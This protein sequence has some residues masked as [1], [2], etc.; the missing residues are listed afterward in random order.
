MINLNLIL[1]ST[2][3]GD[4][5]V[6]PNLDQE[7]FELI[8]KSSVAYKSPKVAKLWE[9]CK[10][11]IYQLT[12]RTQSLG[13]GSKG[14]TMYFSENCTQDDSDRVKEWMKVKKMD[15]F[16]CRTFKTEVDGHKTYEIK[17]ASVEKGEKIGITMPPEEYKGDTFVVTRGDFSNLLAKI[18]LNLAEAKKYAANENQDLMIRNYIESFAEG[19]L[20][21]HKDASR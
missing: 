10:K 2:G 11:S 4:S 15:A 8:I 18:N 19:S 12:E 3:F 13:L 5:K 9:K 1:F 17:L 6:I 21:A 16:L 14:V 20:D 7:K